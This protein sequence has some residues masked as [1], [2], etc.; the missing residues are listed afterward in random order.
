MTLDL[1]AF[2]TALYTIVDDL[3]KRYYVCRKPIRPGRRP[4]LSDSEVLTL[5]LCGQWFGTS[6]RAFVRH[7]SEN[8]TG[9][10]SKHAH[11]ERVQSSQSR[12]V[13][14]RYSIV[15]GSG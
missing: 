5:T 3:Y 4:E 14:S 13:W 6:E 8:W 2:L 9:Y 1:D 11:S 12:P 7:V 15:R 10:F